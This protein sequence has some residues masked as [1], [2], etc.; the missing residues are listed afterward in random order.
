[1]ELLEGE[2]LHERLLR[3]KTLA[4][5]EV[6]KIVTHVGRALMRAHEQNIVHRDLKPANIFLVQNAEAEL[7]KVLDFG[8]AKR[9]SDASPRGLTMTGALVGTPSYMSPEQILSSKA[10]DHRTDLWS[11][12]VIAAECLTGKLPFDSDN[13]PGLALLICHGNPTL[14]SLLGRVPPGFDAWFLRATNVEPSLR[15]ESAA[16]MA[17]ELRQ[18]CAVADTGASRSSQVPA[19]AQPT[20]GVAARLELALVS[21]PPESQAS[22]D[23]WPLSGSAARSRLDVRGWSAL[24]RRL[25]TGMV[26]IPVL[27]IASWALLTKT[28]GTPSPMAVASSAP[29]SSAAIEPSVSASPTRAAG[30]EEPRPASA[31]VAAVVPVE[32]VAASPTVAPLVT[33]PALPGSGAEAKTLVAP[34]APA[35]PPVPGNTPTAGRAR[36]EA[37]ASAPVAPQASKPGHEPKAAAAPAAPPAAAPAAAASPAIVNPPVAP[38][39]FAE[40]APAPLEAQVDCAQPFWTDE[41]GARRVK[42]GCSS[43]DEPGA[44]ASGLDASAVRRTVRR[45]N[46]AVQQN[47]WEPALMARA[48]GVPPYARLTAS[49][50]VEPSGRTRSV[51]ISDAPRDYPGLGRCVEA[52]VRGWAFPPAATSTVTNVSLTFSAQ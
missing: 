4:P 37:R 3:T 15:F 32:P 8:V 36:A 14:P 51:S 30:S 13:L 31:S 35:P 38:M 9:S 33:A 26:S 27:V 41:Q 24:S 29:S 48:P 17:E 50:E 43:I 16:Q 18:V 10:L 34:P 22:L 28:S 12:G 42:P 1:M 44:V 49:I 47:C 5:S 39:P 40:S 6:A 52:L 21:E 11:L 25:I 23:A 46:P 19:P 2:T 20:A 45:Y 7:A